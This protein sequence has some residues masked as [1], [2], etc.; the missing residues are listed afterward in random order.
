[1]KKNILFRAD[2]SSSI[3]TG[4]IM[5]DLVLASNFKKSNVI[6]ATRDLKGH[7]NNKIIEAGFTL[8]ILKS[9]K[10]KEMTTLVR[11]YRVD[12]VV[13]DSY[14]I[15]FKY[16]KALKLKT[17]VKILSFDDNYKKHYCDILLNHNLGAKKRKYKKLVPPD[18]ELRCGSKYTLLRDEFVYE[19]NKQKS[20][21]GYIHR[22]ENSCNSI[23]NFPHL[24]KFECR[25]N[26]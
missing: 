10:L 12:M 5:R 1:M 23:A 26:L 11:K 25:V 13:F 22:I 24:F 16:E 14:D 17:N 2:S 9:N 8:E 4:H 20:R 6:F 21:S 3:G 18:C 7:I 19:K 15:N